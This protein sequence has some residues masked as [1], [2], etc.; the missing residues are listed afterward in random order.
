MIKRVYI[1]SILFVAICAGVVLAFSSQFIW[2]SQSPMSQS[3]NNQI[4]IGPDSATSSGSTPSCGSP[5]PPVT[6]TKGFPFGYSK[7]VSTTTYGVCGGACSPV[8][9]S[10]TQ[11]KQFIFINFIWSSLA[12]AAI[13]FMVLITGSLLI[14]KTK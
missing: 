14:K 7:T 10:T 9:S 11:T 8:P 6:T 2:K 12:W 3:V 5:E 13:V 4:C 1:F